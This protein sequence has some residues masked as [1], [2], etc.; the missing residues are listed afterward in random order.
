MTPTQRAAMQA[1]LAFIQD[2]DRD[3]ND[4][5]ILRP[6]QCEALD[7]SRNALRAALA[8]DVHKPHA[9]MAHDL[10]NVRHV[11]WENISGVWAAAWKA[12]EASRT[13]QVPEPPPPAEPAVEPDP[14]GEV[15]ACNDHGHPWKRVSG[16][17]WS[18]AELSIGQKVYASPPPAEVPMIVDD[19]ID[20]IWM[21][22]REANEYPIGVFARAIEALVRH[23]VGIK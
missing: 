6:S 18:L 9:C 17:E 3:D 11:C 19:E 21:I 4:R 20:D 23:K 2:I 16:Y 12:A 1:A 22:A 5:D 15:V 10:E 14:I 7:A 8:E 13:T